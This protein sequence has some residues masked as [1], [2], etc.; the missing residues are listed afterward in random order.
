M[1]SQC[2]TIR[3][4]SRKF[5]KF[6]KILAQTFLNCESTCDSTDVSASKYDRKPAAQPFNTIHDII[7]SLSLMQSLLKGRNEL[8]WR[9]GDQGVKIGLYINRF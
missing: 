6:V 2:R 8:I 4:Q 5:V 7:R 9:I 3:S 1:T